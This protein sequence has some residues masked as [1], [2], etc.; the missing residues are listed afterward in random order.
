MEQCK[1][2]KV[3]KVWEWC[4]NSYLQR[5]LKLSFP[6]D[7]DPTKTYQ[8]RYCQKLSDKLDEWKFDEETAKYFIDTAISYARNTKSF[9]KGLSVLHQGNILELAYSAII[10]RT[11]FD[12]FVRTKRWLD[13]Q[14][15]DKDQIATLLRSDKDSH[16]NIAIWHQTGRLSIQYI[17]LS[18]KCC[19]AIS[20]L[21][22][23]NSDDVELLPSMAELYKARIELVNSGNKAKLKQILGND[24]RELCQ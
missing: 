4:L 7:T 3:W 5:G 16:S 8:W 15:G 14:L 22:N 13:N 24:W 20:I 1:D 9:K 10:D 23:A 21:N 11:P 2:I 12:S 17:T 19:K 18:K 6:K